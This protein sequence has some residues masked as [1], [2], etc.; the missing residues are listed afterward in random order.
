MTFT[1]QLTLTYPVQNAICR[2][3]DAD[4][5][6]CPTGVLHQ[7]TSAYNTPDSG[8]TRILYKR[9]NTFTYSAV[10]YYGSNSMTGAFPAQGALN[11]RPLIQFTGTTTVDSSI[12]VKL[13]GAQQMLVFTIYNSICNQLPTELREQA[14]SMEAAKLYFFYERTSLIMVLTWLTVAEPLGLRTNISSSIMVWMIRLVII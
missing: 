7:T 12:P 6:G 1:L 14:D 2:S 3:N 5:T 4:F 8:N 9:G 11:S 10:G 13:G